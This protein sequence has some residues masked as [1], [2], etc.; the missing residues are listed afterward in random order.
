[1][2]TAKE[3]NG[4]E[5][6]FRVLERTNVYAKHDRGSSLICIC[7]VREGCSGETKW[8]LFCNIHS[9]WTRPV[10]LPHPLNFAPSIDFGPT[11]GKR[12]E[13]KTKRGHLV[14]PAPPPPGPSWMLTRRPAGK[15]H[16]QGSTS[17]GLILDLE[18]LRPSK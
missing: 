10:R 2:P 11:R 8:T 12:P 17:F 4:K 5:T 13:Q 3:F 7:S 1:M 6:R 15:P 16:L 18:K 14:P 9:L